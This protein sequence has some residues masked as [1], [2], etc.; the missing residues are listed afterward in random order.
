MV[1]EVVN[2][3]E[4]LDESS[5]HFYQ[6][7]SKFPRTSFENINEM[8]SIKF[9]R[10]EV[11]LIELN[12]NV[13]ENEMT[14][15]FDTGAQIT[16]MTNR[17][18]KKVNIENKANEKV[19]V[20]SSNSLK[21]DMEIALVDKITIGKT[22]IFNLPVL[23]I[24]DNNLPV[25]F[26]G[27]LGWDILSNLDFEIDV[28]N[29]ELRIITYSDEEI[30]P[31][32]M[33]SSFPTVLVTDETNQIRTFG[34]DTG[35]TRSWINEKL[36]DKASLKVVKIE[37]EERMGLHG[38]EKNQLKIIEE[39]KIHIYDSVFTCDNIRTGRTILLNNY[40]F[41]GVIGSDVMKDNVVKVI[42]SKG[43]FIIEE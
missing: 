11:G 26:D 24:D 42:N 14:F 41:D 15:L 36:I 29:S 23:V 43:L 35:A 20:G 19:E 3:S 5:K 22:K 38:K 34:I 18:L 6:I 2:A 21:A 32:L 8:S 37:E 7:T 1:N 12:I 27:I 39:L 4:D 30:T 10:H 33:K 17:A 13:N 25:H 28:K 40:G 31:N 9:R 16:L